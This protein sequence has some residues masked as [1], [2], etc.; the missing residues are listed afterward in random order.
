MNENET[1]LARALSEA[2]TDRQNARRLA[3]SARDTYVKLGQE[4]K[5]AV[6]KAWLASH[7]V[8]AR[9]TQP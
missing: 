6:A 7:T 4:K 5:A 8:A 9:Q 3:E 1:A 2:G